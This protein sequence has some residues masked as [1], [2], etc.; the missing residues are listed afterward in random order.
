MSAFVL[1]ERLDFSND[2]PEITEPFLATSMFS[3]TVGVEKGRQH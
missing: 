2:T 1:L 3:V